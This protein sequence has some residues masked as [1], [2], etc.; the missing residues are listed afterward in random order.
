MD[1]KKVLIISV[2][3][4]IALVIAIVGT[5]YAMFTA[6][7]TGTK[8]NA[9]KTGYVKM[10]CTETTFNV[11]NASPMSDAV[12]IAA[13]NNSATCTLTTEMKGTMKIGYDVA[14]YDVDAVTPSDSI[15]V[16]NVKMQIYKSIDGGAATYLGGSSASAGVLVNTLSSARGTYDT[17]I[18]SYNVDSATVEGNQSVVYTIKN[19]VASSG[20]GSNTS[21]T[22]A[23]KCSN[24]T[25]TTEETCKAA[26]EIWGSSQTQSQAGG[27]FSFKLKVGAT[28]VLS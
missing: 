22:N 17:S 21:S 9:I 5:S 3:S 20:S 19:W 15:G 11:E 23:G 6:N 7:L 13:T 16:G 14:L 4:V 12:G 10:N 26:G 18:T 24:E 2:I 8:E 25:Y 28:Q 27:S 1:N